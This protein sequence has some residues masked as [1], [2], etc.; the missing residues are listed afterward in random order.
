MFSSHHWYKN[1][2]RYLFKLRRLW[3]DWNDL[4]LLIT[5][6]KWILLVFPTLCYQKIAT[7]PQ[8][9]CITH[10]PAAGTLRG[11]IAYNAR[12]GSA[13]RGHC[14]CNDFNLL[15][16]LGN[17]YNSKL[18]IKCKLKR[19]IIWYGRFQLKHYVYTHTAKTNTL[20]FRLY[21]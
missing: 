3:Q 12:S 21:C 18:F 5:I 20:L 2:H 8:A 11:K 10:P 16:T 13:H 14:L 1:N 17:L 6:F 19:K 15:L 4:T 9:K 7:K